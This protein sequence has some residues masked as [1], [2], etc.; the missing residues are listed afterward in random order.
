MN[1]VS[2]T[3][4]AKKKMYIYTYICLY[5]SFKQNK[6]KN[7]QFTTSRFNFHEPQII[8]AFRF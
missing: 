2:K 8:E 4:K 1:L 6:Y 3:Y 7:Y 5:I